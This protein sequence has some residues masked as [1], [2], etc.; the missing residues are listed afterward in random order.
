MPIRAVVFDLF[1]T[2]VD[3]SMS[4]LPQIEVGGRRFPST[5]GELHAVASRHCDIGLEGFVDV[6]R[7]VDLGFRESRYARGLEL[8]TL[9]RM[10][11][12]ADKL[13]VDD[14]ALP[15][16]LAAAHMRLLR[17]QVSL[18]AHHGEVLSALGRRA[19]LALCSNF[20]HSETALGLLEEYD[21]ARHLDVLVISD[22]IGIRK[23]RPEIFEAVLEQLGVR[24]EETL[25]VGDSL[26]ADVDGA[27]L[28]GLRTV[29]IT[30]RVR[31]A[32]AALAAHEGASPDHVIEDLAELEVLLEH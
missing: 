24:P 5:A 28:L 3:I 21:L 17:G 2:L 1:D 29:W 18:P 15:Q 8:P 23:P 14:A 25:H 19:S 12:V 13:G 22:A 30:R 4:G 32:D 11:A 16:A 31:D 6:L 9:E 27:A 10:Q 26:T 20:S 7:E